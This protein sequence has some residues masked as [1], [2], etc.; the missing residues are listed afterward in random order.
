MGGAHPRSA[1]ATEPGWRLDAAGAKGSA[2]LDLT[3]GVQR[4]GTAA[5]RAPM[6]PGVHRLDL[7]LT[8][9][10]GRLAT[11]SVDLYVHPRRDGPP[12]GAVSVFAQDAALAERLRA[13]GYRQARSAATADVILARTPEKDSVSAC[14][15]G[16]RLVLLADQPFDLD[17]LFPH[18]QQVRVARRHGTMWLGCW[19][20]SFSWLRRTGP[21]GRLPGG[22]LLDHG[23]ERV[24]PDH[25]ITGLNGWTFRGCALAGMVVGWVHK[26]AA[27]LVDQPYGRGRVVATTFRLLEDA[28]G[29]DPTATAL[30][31]G[32][33]EQALAGARR[34][35]PEVEL[36][37]AA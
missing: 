24:I 19:A 17:P 18:W 12:A 33:V 7:E 29:I 36:T 2:A 16:G 5:F 27:L 6:T 14:R 4:A 20:S 30:L 3:P 22:P 13:L 37:A 34:A 11:N 35:E 25:V 15:D 10:D 9:A 1:N 21:F 32:L 8:A 28:P 23:F 26:P 31:D